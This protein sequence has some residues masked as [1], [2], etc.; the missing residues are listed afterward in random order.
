MR[1]S[2]RRRCVPIAIAD[3]CLRRRCVDLRECGGPSAGTVGSGAVLGG[4]GSGGRSGLGVVVA[5]GVGEAHAGLIRRGRTGLWPIRC[6]S[7][8][9][10]ALQCFAR[11]TLLCR[12]RPPGS[13]SITTA[14]GSS[15][16]AVM[17]AVRSGSTSAGIAIRRRP[18]SEF[19]VP[20]A[21]RL[22][23]SRSVRV[24]ATRTRPVTRST[25]PGHVDEL[26]HRRAR[27]RTWHWRASGVGPLGNE[28]S[29]GQ[30]GC[31]RRSADGC[32]WPCLRRRGRG[33]AGRRRWPCVLGDSSGVVRGCWSAV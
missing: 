19:G 26:A 29:G 14:A 31:P 5:G 21:S 9:V 13:P 23:S 16:K 30:G 33:R 18:A 1:G 32:A 6:I 22:P 20:S 27:E 4:A 17:C 25:S 3:G 10:V 2:G 24:R 28:V 11:R 15:P 8:R 12:S 7:S